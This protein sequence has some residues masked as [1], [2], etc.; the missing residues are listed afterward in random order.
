MRVISS[1]TRVLQKVAGIGIFSSWF[2][3]SFFNFATSKANCDRLFLI[4]DMLRSNQTNCQKTP[5]IYQ[6]SFYLKES[7]GPGVKRLHK[8]HVWYFR[9]FPDI[10]YWECTSYLNNTML[11]NFI[12]K[13]CKRYGQLCKKTHNFLRKPKNYL[14][15]TR[16]YWKIT[17]R[18]HRKRGRIKVYLACECF[19]PI[20]MYHSLYFR[21]LFQF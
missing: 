18:F 11:G 7:A 3:V 13:K 10:R 8:Y 9:H 1:L 5:Q 6:N 21:K 20:S 12:K 19:L 4:L 17:P 14:K 16:L 15:K 2:E